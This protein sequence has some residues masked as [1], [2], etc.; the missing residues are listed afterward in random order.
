MDFLTANDRAGTYP[1]SYYTATTDLPTPSPRLEGDVTADV[2]IVGGG[3][4]G[5][6]A[7][8]HC[9]ERGLRVVLLEANRVGWGAS[10]RNGGQLGAGQRV[11]QPELEKLVGKDHAHRLW[12]LARE[13]VS[14]VKSL[15]ADHGIAC[16]LKPG[17]LHADHKTRY[18][19][20]SRAFVEHLERHYDYHAA[21][22]VGREELCE[23]IGSTAY[24]S[25][26][27]DT[28]A[29]HLHPLRLAVG[30]AK[31]ARTAGAILHENTRVIAVGDGS[32]PRIETDHGTV[33][34]EHVLIACNGYLGRLHPRI[35]TRVMPINN[36]IVATEPL[37]ET[38]AR[39][40]IRDD[41]AVADSKFVVN[42]WRL[43]SDRRLLFGGR[44]SYRYR[45]PNN[46]KSFVQKP[47][48][49]VYPQLQDVK[50]DYGWGGT[51]AVTMNRL[52][53]FERLAPTVLSA[54]GYSGHG[55]GMATLAGKLAAEAIAGQAERFDTF[56]AIPTPGFP[57][58]TALRWPL[59]V[60]GMT[61]YSLRD[62][63]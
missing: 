1:E 27:L 15:I 58:G 56:A 22:F 17:V 46:I 18:T 47:M 37:P 32:R 23:M 21:R 3:Y 13:S 50:I 28:E 7:A 20:D 29:A 48:L 61:Y 5:L 24:H 62:R 42:Y 26:V 39:E 36:Y 59:L 9:A 14:L 57:G 4:T 6:S 19:E 44:E 45:F 31:A 52:P 40:L 54:S 33:T 35:A 38:L 55:V 2:C 11:E 12:N 63:L 51:L 49:Y 30:L 34:A 8:L 43:S 60:L 53:H 10:G 41:V 16:D 25:G